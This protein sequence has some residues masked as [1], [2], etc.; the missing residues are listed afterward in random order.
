MTPVLVIAALGVVLSGSLCRG[1]ENFRVGD[2]VWSIPPYPDFYNDWSSSHFF[3]VGD[4]LVFDFE[5]ELHNVMEV[6]RR[7]YESC[8]AGNP[9]RAIT[10]GPAT[11]PLMGERLYFTGGL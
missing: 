5:S 6:S 11:I 9:F 1:M 7:D 8:T 2:S 10:V 4:S 3:R